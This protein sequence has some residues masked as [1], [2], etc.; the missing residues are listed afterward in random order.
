MSDNK[1]AYLKDLL[2][3]GKRLIE[4]KHRLIE[5]NR[6][7]K[8]ANNSNNHLQTIA[9]TLSKTFPPPSTPSTPLPGGSATQMDLEGDLAQIEE[10]LPVFFDLAYLAR[11]QPHIPTALAQMASATAGTRNWTVEEVDYLLRGMRGEADISEHPASL[12]DFITESAVNVGGDSD[13]RDE[14]DHSK[15]DMSTVSL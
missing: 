14:A 13:G 5:E 1:T 7:N 9:A 11:S 4:E 3:K 2:D 6:R 8:E 10:L 12:N 15:G